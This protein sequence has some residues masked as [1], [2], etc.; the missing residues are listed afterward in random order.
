MTKPWQFHNRPENQRGQGEGKQKEERQGE[1]GRRKG[2]NRGTKPQTP[3]LPADGESKY[4]SATSP[5]VVGQIQ[6][7]R[8]RRRKNWKGTGTE[9][10]QGSRW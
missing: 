10:P 3:P 7:R 2:G 1:I 5:E 9:I 8:T 4:R 6:K